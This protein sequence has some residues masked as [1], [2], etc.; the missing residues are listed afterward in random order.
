[1]IQKFEFVLKENSKFL[2][3]SFNNFSKKKTSEPFSL[4][5][6]M[7]IIGKAEKKPEKKE[8]SS[9]DIS[10]LIVLNKSKKKKNKKLSEFSN[11]EILKSVSDSENL[12]KNN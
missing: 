6:L 2:K 10:E 5:V 12:I 3:Y 8:L 7:K 1:M 11:L 4:D 9:S